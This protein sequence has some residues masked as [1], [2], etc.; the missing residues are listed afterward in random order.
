MFTDSADPRRIKFWRNRFKDDSLMYAI[1][2]F[3]EHAKRI[4]G[5]LPLMRQNI[6]ELR[7]ILAAREISAERRGNP[8]FL[9]NL[10]KDDLLKDLIAALPPE[11]QSFALKALR[12]RKQEQFVR[13][14]AKTIINNATGQEPQ[15]KSKPARRRI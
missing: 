7:L 3:P 6:L 4:F 9:T 11:K 15:L 12:P 2:V 14:F 1:T 13:D 10:L 8:K 5:A